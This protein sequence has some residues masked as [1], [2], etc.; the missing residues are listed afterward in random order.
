MA[1]HR[2]IEL[3][4]FLSKY[5][6]TGRR[7]RPPV[8]LKTRPI[9]RLGPV[10]KRRADIVYT[11]QAVCKLIS[12]LKNPGNIRR[13]ID[14]ISQNN[15]IELI[16]KYGN[17]ITGKGWDTALAKQ[18][19]EE[20]KIKSELR[21]RKQRRDSV[22]AVHLMFSSPN[23]ANSRQNELATR[24]LVKQLFPDH[25]F[26]LA[27][28]TDTSNLHTHV[29]LNNISQTGKP[30]AW[31][32]A[33]LQILRESWAHNQRETGINVTCSN[34]NDRA[35]YQPGL[36]M[37]QV[38]I[39]E[40][41]EKLYFE[42]NDNTQEEKI[43]WLSKQIQHTHELFLALLRDKKRLLKEKNKKNKKNI[44]D[45]D[46]KLTDIVEKTRGHVQE[47]A[48]DY[49]PEWLK[50]KPSARSSGTG[51]DKD[52]KKKKDKTET[53][54]VKS[55]KRKSSDGGPSITHNKNKTIEHEI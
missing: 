51:P 9:R 21:G 30:L 4:D 19:T 42:D 1:L 16:D 26:V 49:M 29:I 2:N 31:R 35:E 7:I 27:Q 34:R 12:K 6:R 47:H 13:S 22:N 33:N 55:R 3:E 36:S 20:N 43:A 24:T 10:G 40:K 39:Q 41:G 38:K 8:E 50:P 17:K 32:K 28:H 5:R 15:T 11:P 52:T 48:P 37:A 53:I 44:D 23:D 25:D 18:W 54:T 46:K 45:I 14:Y